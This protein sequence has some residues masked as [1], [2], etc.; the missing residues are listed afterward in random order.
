[1]LLSAA[2]LVFAAA[3]G[4]AD[5]VKVD[6]PLVPE[7]S[8]KSAACSTCTAKTHKCCTGRFWDWL[9]YQP[10]GHTCCC[11]RFFPQC[12][13]YQPPLYC[14]FE[15]NCAT[16]CGSCNHAVMSCDQGGACGAGCKK[17]TCSSCG[18]STSCS[19]CDERR[20][21]LLDCLKK[22]KCDQEVLVPVC[23]PVPASD[24]V[25]APTAVKADAK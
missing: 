25:T 7:A 22:N 10:A 18:S 20:F 12:A 1:M 24:A 9:T 16:T 19:T 6:A 17:A 3:C 5:D 21:H 4:R 2:V 11:P 13:P 14:Y 15:S 23:A 8:C